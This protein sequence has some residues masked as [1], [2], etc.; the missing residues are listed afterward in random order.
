MRA[1]REST[2]RKARGAAVA[3]ALIAAVLCGACGVALADDAKPPAA[4]DEKANLDEAFKKLP[5]YEFGQSRLP[6]TTVADAVREASGDPKARAATE[7]RLLAVL[8][9]GATAD[10]K[11]FVCRQLRLIG[12]AASVPALAKLLD[13]KALSHMARFALEPMSDPAAGAA[14]REA[15]GRLDGERLIGVVNSLGRRRDEKAVGALV[16]LL[17]AKDVPVAAAAAAALGKVGGADAAEALA[18]ARAKAPPKLKPVVTDAWLLCADRMV[19]A[20]RRQEA[21]AVYEKLYAPDEPAPVRIAALR[22]LVAAGGADAAPRLV[23]LL[24]GDDARLRA[25]AVRCVREVE[26]PAATKAFASALPSLSPS[27][28]VLLLEA[29]AAR[30]DPVAAPAVLKAAGHENEEVRVAAVK[31]LAPLGGKAA[32]GPL[33]ALATGDGKVA[34]AARGSL[35]RLRGKGVDESLLKRLSTADDAAARVELIRA[36]GLRRTDAAAG[37]LLKAAGDENASVRGAAIEALGRVAGRKELDKLVALLVAAPE[38]QRATA[39]KAVLAACSRISDKDACA[40]VVVS[41]AAKAPGPVRATLLRMLGRIGGKPALKALLAATRD[42]DP[43]VADAAVRTLATW[44]DPAPADELLKIARGAA[45]PAHRILALRGYVRMA[46]MGRPSPTK[47]VAA[48][49]RAAQL[50]QRPEEKKLIIGALAGVG[51]LD[52]LKL[53]A[54][55][56]DEKAVS[57]EAASAAMKIIGRVAKK[58]PSASVEVLEKIVKTTTDKRLKKQA[59]EALKKLKPKAGKRGRALPPTA[60]PALAAACLPAVAAAAKGTATVPARDPA[61]AAAAE[62]LGWRLGVQAYTFRKFTFFQAVDK[63]A[64]LGL[65]VIEIYP[66]Q[67][68]SAERKGRTHHGMSADDLAAVKARLDDAGVKAVCYGVVGLGRDEKAHRR[69]FDFCRK[70]GIETITTETRP[71]ELLDKLAGEYGISLALHN[72]PNSWPPAKVLAACKGRSRRI[73]ACADTG[74]WMRAGINPVEALKQLRGRIVSLHFKDLNKMGRGAHD[75][76]WGTGVGDVKAMLAELHRQG[77][78][79]VFSI[80]YEHNW[81]DSMGD[82]AR[83]I[84]CFD[85]IALELAGQG[86]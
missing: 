22:G 28:Q 45:R 84:A 63:A 46:G 66:G 58:H 42:D 81:S 2:L 4:D 24:K 27:E 1:G 85:R 35:A 75:V 61:G 57:R 62:K 17:G 9:T 82:I 80:E 43:A 6:L 11:R 3:A 16:K 86:G 70:M 77:F 49:K 47:L 52:A 13:D 34:D 68:I 79:G 54:N 53:A 5:G 65:K 21:A 71:T 76:P 12:T 30:A 44:G 78:K 56:L 20:G 33:L 26:G 10:A 15:M 72:H 32:V 40:S 60:L 73:G 50:A 39:E 74:H 38:D 14:L 51:H 7:R 29:L 37:A 55:Y 64:A 25:T 48:L 31:A 41:A 69:V 59:S 83:C 36:L 8:E 67:R 19:E 23:E 18:D